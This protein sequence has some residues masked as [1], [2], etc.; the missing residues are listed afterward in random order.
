MLLH[1]PIVMA[2]KMEIV[3]PSPWRVCSARAAWAASLEM[4][5]SKQEVTAVSSSLGYHHTQPKRSSFSSADTPGWLPACDSPTIPSPPQVSG[6]AQLTLQIAWANLS[7]C[8]PRVPV[9][10]SPFAHPL[11]ASPPS[12][13]VHPPQRCWKISPALLPPGSQQETCKEIFC[14]IKMLKVVP[15]DLSQAKKHELIFLGVLES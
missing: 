12:T 13:R 10:I 2:P 7:H 1:L 6:L 9:N 8:R 11:S 15:S 5:A 14:K 4:C 3:C